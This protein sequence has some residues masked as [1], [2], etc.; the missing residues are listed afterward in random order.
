MTTSLHVAL[1]YLGGGHYDITTGPD[2]GQFVFTNVETGQHHKTAGTERYVKMLLPKGHE[3]VILARKLRDG[4]CD[5]FYLFRKN[6]NYEQE[7]AAMEREW[8]QARADMV[9]GR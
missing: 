5:G 3:Y 2:S 7:R 9:G 8:E 1:E 6:E 4:R